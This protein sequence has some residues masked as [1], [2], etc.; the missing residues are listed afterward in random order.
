MF[1]PA[2]TRLTADHSGRKIAAPKGCRLID[3]ENSHVS[4]HSCNF[5][6]RRGEG[7]DT[8]RFKDTVRNCQAKCHCLTHDQAITPKSSR[9]A[10]FSNTNTLQRFVWLPESITLVFDAKGRLN[11]EIFAKKCECAWLDRPMTT[12]G[13]G[14]TAKWTVNSGTVKRR[15]QNCV[16]RKLA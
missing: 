16:G 4:G 12:S 6:T 11:W 8:P 13:R 3:M 15:L 2:D 9:K 10:V 1:V 14:W 7:I 5:S